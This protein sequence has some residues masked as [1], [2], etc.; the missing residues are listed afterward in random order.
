[1]T[2]L[3]IFKKYSTA[4]L[5]LLSI[6]DILLFFNAEN[7]FA[8]FV[9]L[10]GWLLIEKLVL[11]PSVI[12][13]APISF[14]L[15]LGLGFCY[16]YLP[17]V[18]TLIEYKP[19]T[20]KMK[21]PVETYLHQFLYITTVILTYRFY[22]HATHFNRRNPFKNI[23][24]NLGINS[25]INERQITFIGIIGLI[26]GFSYIFIYRDSFVDENISHSVT[27][28]LLNSMIPF[29]F[30]PL[31]LKFKELYTTDYKKWK[32]SN[33]IFI[34]FAVA[35]FIYALGR[36]SRT[37]MISVVVLI[38]TL[39]MMGCFL[40]RYN[41]KKILSI[42]KIAITI[43]FLYILFGPMLQ[44]GTAMVIVRLKGAGYA[45]RTDY[46]FAET[47]ETFSDKRAI[48][49]YTKLTNNSKNSNP[50]WDEVWINNIIINRLCNL[51]IADL[52]I[53]HANKVGY[54][55]SN[56]RQNFTDRIICI[57][58]QFVINALNIN[59]NKDKTLIA[60]HT[61][62]LFSKSMSSNISQYVGN[63]VAAPTGL[64]LAT[65]GYFYLPIL[66]IVYFF[67]F[68]LFDSF[69][70]FKNGKTML[71]II[72]IATIY[73][74]ILYFNY[75]SGLIGDIGFI[76]RGWFQIIIINT[77]IVTITKKII[78]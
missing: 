68:L 26:A 9:I 77:I 17:L 37:Y 25:D 70:Y 14:L 39:Y 65:F 48:A 53:Y 7:I 69:S 32:Y 47:L 40:N 55:D 71:S 49:E 45:S 12:E 51:K 23:L 8:C 59:I 13:K 22:L 63:R 66:A 74:I 24:A 54:N 61:D 29:M 35:I 50:N 42:K 19:L 18:F 67:V 33:I 20:F 36:N 62:Y 10:Y 58:P 2:F 6:I 46:L 41:Y 76:L 52:S 11:L 75:K 57:L 5:V 64:G 15:I 31:A 3:S 30:Y 27:A 72:A 44:F 43:F 16:Y 38:I 4:I 60:N 78:H 1:M 28:T 34:T 21:V 73:N 56:I